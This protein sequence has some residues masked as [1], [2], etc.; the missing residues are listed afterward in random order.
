MPEPFETKRTDEI[1]RKH[2]IESDVNKSDNF[3]SEEV[4]YNKQSDI[5]QSDSNFKSDITNNSDN[6]NDVNYN[7]ENNTNVIVE[8]KDFLK[9]NHNNKEISVTIRNKESN[10]ITKEDISLDNT[11][12]MEN[13]LIPEE[14]A[15]NVKT[16]FDVPKTSK[17]MTM[18]LFEDNFLTDTARKKHKII[19]QVFDTYWIVE[20]EDK[21]TSLTNMRLMK[22]L[23]LKKLW[24]V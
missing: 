11:S 24:L 10:Q 19:G 9:N 3:I 14:K 6:I 12:N 23:C 1:E 16:R 15:V 20:Y 22:K 18:N 13:A 17:D 21:C 2:D 4:N 5:K 7:I 8:N